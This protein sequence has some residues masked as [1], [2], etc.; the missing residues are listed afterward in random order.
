MKHLKQLAYVALQWHW[1]EMLLVIVLGST[2]FFIWCG[3]SAIIHGFPC[4][5]LGTFGS[6]LFLI[7]R[8]FKRTGKY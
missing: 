5:L 3:W 1:R 7:H 4:V 2:P 6:T 8:N